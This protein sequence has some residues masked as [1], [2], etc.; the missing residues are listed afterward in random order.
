VDVCHLARELEFGRFA[1]GGLAIVSGQEG[2][3]FAD[4]VPLIGDYLGMERAPVRYADGDSPSASVGDEAGVQLRAR[5]RRE[6]DAEKEG[7]KPTGFART[8]ERT[9]PSRRDGSAPPTKSRRATFDTRLALTDTRTP[10]RL[11]PRLYDEARI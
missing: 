10:P 2:G 11:R 5:A 4:F 1:V 9:A 7:G 6:R 3:P 8:T